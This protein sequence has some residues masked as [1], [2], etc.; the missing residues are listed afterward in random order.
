M[1]AKQIAIIQQLI[2]RL[3]GKPFTPTSRVS[4]DWLVQTEAKFNIT[5]PSGY[6]DF[7]LQMGDQCPG[8]H[9]QL[10][11]LQQA[12][13]EYRIAPATIQMLQQ[14]FL[15]V[16]EYHPENE[17]LVVQAEE[18]VNSGKISS[19]QFDDLIAYYDVYFLGGTLNIA[20]LGCGYW[21]K[22]V[23]NGPTRGEVWQDDTAVDC[24]MHPLGLSF[25]D[26]YQSWLEKSLQEQ[27]KGRLHITGNNNQ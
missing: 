26:W 9:G 7:L 2:E 8:P 3:L 15:A 12:L 11:S 19:Q 20:D 24:G 21:I 23:V 22:L 17:A 10:I 13:D 4:L 5:L 1:N 14:E 16:E 18:Q 27:E 25:L 6:R